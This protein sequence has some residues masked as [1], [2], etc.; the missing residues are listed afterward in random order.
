M[1]YLWKNKNTIMTI[2]EIDKEL[3]LKLIDNKYY[4]GVV[5]KGSFDALYDYNRGIYTLRIHKWK[6]GK[7]VIL[8]LSTIDD[9][10]WSAE[11]D[12][13]KEENIKKLGEDF[14]ETYGRTLPTEEEFNVFLRK[15]GLYGMYSG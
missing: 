9:G 13:F 12:N 6:E 15:Y 1:Q 5:L 14:I 4:Q 10:V 2:Y 7:Q 3:G 11:S 8:S